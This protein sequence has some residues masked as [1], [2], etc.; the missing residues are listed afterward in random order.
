[1]RE[2]L[3][4]RSDYFLLVCLAT[5]N[6]Y[7]DIRR[8]VPW[9]DPSVSP[10]VLESFTSKVHGGQFVTVGTRRGEI[11]PYPDYMPVA[12]RYDLAYESDE[13]I[14]ISTDLGREFFCD[15]K[16]FPH[17]DGSMLAVRWNDRLPFRGPLRSSH[18]WEANSSIR[19][20]YA[21]Q[22]IDYDSWVSYIERKM[23]FDNFMLGQDMINV[24]Q[25]AGTSV[26][27]IAVLTATVAIS[28]TNFR[29]V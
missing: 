5:L 20:D 14:K 24:Y 9:G 15:C 27:K 19:I 22:V 25:L 7:P 10:D 13:T 3:M 2:G 17:N 18:P 16:V 6:A 4:L 28:N 12:T 1:M 29:D 23:P 26:E 21:P 11:L 8:L